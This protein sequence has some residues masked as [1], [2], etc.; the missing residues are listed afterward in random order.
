MFYF[1]IIFTFFF[2][3][4]GDDIVFMA[5]S[6]EKLF[7]QKVSQMPKEECEVTAI[8]TTKEP[9]KGRQTAAG[10]LHNNSGPILHVY[11]FHLICQITGLYRITGFEQFV[12]FMTVDCRYI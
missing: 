4:P 3:Q 12:L 1:V 5:Q 9:V 7:L 6:L 2:P 8:I 10:M 11:F